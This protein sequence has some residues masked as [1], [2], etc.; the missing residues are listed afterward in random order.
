MCNFRKAL[1]FTAIPAALFAIATVVLILLGVPIAETE[2]PE[3]SIADICLYISMVVVGAAFLSSIGFAIMRK[4]DIAKGTA[5]GGGI[6]L[7]V[8]LIAFGI[9]SMLYYD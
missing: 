6:G 4:K 9:G 7:V 2:F 3:S 5:F 8:W 1:M